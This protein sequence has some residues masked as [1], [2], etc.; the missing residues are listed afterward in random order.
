MATNIASALGIGKR[1]NL[2]FDTAMDRTRAALKEQA[3][4]C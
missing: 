1:L 3:S 2:A 4:A